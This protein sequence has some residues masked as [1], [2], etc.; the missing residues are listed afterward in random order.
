LYDSEL[1]KSFKFPE[2]IKCLEDVQWNYLVFSKARKVALLNETTYAYRKNLNSIT[3]TWSLKMVEQRLQSL[4]LLEQ[5]L[6]N[7]KEARQWLAIRVLTSYSIICECCSYTNELSGIHERLKIINNIYKIKN[8]RILEETN[9][10]KN[11]NLKYKIKR[12]LAVHGLLP[13]IYI[14]IA[15]IKG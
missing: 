2:E 13:I 15:K 8:W 3:H 9:I 11:W 5:T 12:L 1:A 10:G 4:S 7:N 6:E 14:F